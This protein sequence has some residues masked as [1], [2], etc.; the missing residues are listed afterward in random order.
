VIAK[1]KKKNSPRVNLVISLVFHSIIVVT[2]FFFAAREGLLGKQLKKIAVTMVPKEKPPEKPKELEP[3][4]EPPKIDTPK[5]VEPSQ[6]AQQPKPVSAPPPAATIAPAVAPP[7]AEVPSFEFGGGK[8]VETSSNPVILYK[9]FVEYTL[10]SKW[11]RPDDIQDDSY[12]AELELAIGPKGQ[13]TDVEW[14]K[15][16]GDPRWDDS[17]RRVMAQTRSISRP[18]PKGFPERF[19]VRFDVQ[20]LTEPVLQ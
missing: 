18:P 2:L 6:V 15:G 8:I 17:V 13:I 14:K 20:P 9:G 5:P 16:S 10:R 4:P 19:L 1:R 11:E 7:P 3:K 12:I